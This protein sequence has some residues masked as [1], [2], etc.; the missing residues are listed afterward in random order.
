MV[1]NVGNLYFQF[2]IHQLWAQ[3]LILSGSDREN[4]DSSQL[5]CRWQ[6]SFC[7]LQQEEAILNYRV[8]IGQGIDVQIPGHW[9]GRRGPVRW[10]P[11]L[12][13]LDF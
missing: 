10:P 7:C 3:R 6:V 1:W 9:A 5:G 12:T 13:R 11:D 4:S 2:L 8:N